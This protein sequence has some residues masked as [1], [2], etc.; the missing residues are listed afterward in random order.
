[1]PL[2]EVAILELPTKKEIEEGTG[3]EKLAFGPQSVVAKD[4][5]SAA[6]KAVL[7]N[8]EAAGKVD[9]AR[10]QVLVRPFA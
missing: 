1:M 9:K 10:M 3:E 7:E 5:Q 2:F 6:I 4:G 8:A